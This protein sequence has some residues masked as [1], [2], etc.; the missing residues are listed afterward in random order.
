MEV[1]GDDSIGQHRSTDY[2]AESS[3]EDSDSEF[4]G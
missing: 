4:L 3:R 2:D 1:E